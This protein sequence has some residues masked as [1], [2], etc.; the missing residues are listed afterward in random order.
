MLPL[1]ALW[2]ASA[3]SATA[4]IIDRIAV[5]VGNR[6]ITYSEIER[7]A[8]LTAFL[9]NEQPDL[10]AAA[11]RKTAERLIEQRLVGR[12]LEAARYPEPAASE[13]EA[14]LNGLRKRYAAAGSLKQALAAYR[15]TEEDLRE[16][17]VWQLRFLRFIDIRF[18]PGVQVTEEEVRE[19]FEKTI[20]PVAAQA[21]PGRKPVLE[22]Y[23]EQIEEALTGQRVDREVERWLAAARRRTRVEFREG[24]FE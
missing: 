20:R 2:M 9:N 13:V 17:L 7:Q 8:R 19:Y 3:A 24:A 16:H 6:V 23:R 11:R 10:S 4:E 1:L 18:R 21:Q 14:T 5:S 22:E 15:I 12:E